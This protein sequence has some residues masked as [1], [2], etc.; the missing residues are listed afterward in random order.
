MVGRERFYKSFSVNG[1]MRESALKD[2]SDPLSIAAPVSFIRES[3][4]VGIIHKSILKYTNQTRD[5]IDLR[6]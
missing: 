5:S 4:I 3:L 1:K 6:V 2:K